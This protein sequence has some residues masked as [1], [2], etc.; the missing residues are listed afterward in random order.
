MDRTSFRLVMTGLA[1]LLGAVVA[2]AFVLNP[3]GDDLALPDPVVS[4]APAPDVAVLPQIGVVVV[5]EP[6]YRI[7]MEVDGVP[8]P[9]AELGFTE[10]TGRYTWEPGPGRAL[11]SWAPGSHRVVITW[12]RVV[13]LPDPGSYGWAFRVQ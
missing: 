10:A 5:M 8:V 1:L 2:L 3:S 13:G 11:E 7:A 6:G 12:D 4:V 9:E